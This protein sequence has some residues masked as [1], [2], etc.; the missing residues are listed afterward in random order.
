LGKYVDF[1]QISKPPTQGRWEIFWQTTF[2][3]NHIRHFLSNE[4]GKPFR[5]TPN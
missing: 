1:H 5:V 3:I 4:C 2:F